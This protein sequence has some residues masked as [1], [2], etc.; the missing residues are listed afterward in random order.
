MPKKLPSQEWRIANDH[1]CL[2]PLRF[3]AVGVQKCVAALDSFQWLKYGVARGVETMLAHPLYFPYPHRYARQLHGEPI[4]LDAQHIL[5]T[6]ERRRSSDCQTM[7]ARQ[8]LPL[9]ICFE[10]DVLER[11]ERQV[12]KVAG[13]AS[14][15]EHTEVTKPCL[16]GLPMALR[17]TNRILLT[18]PLR[19]IK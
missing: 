18:L 17:T 4:D 7:R 15:I 16:E 5:W 13:A 12:Q 1:V 10:F 14:W 9:L 11:F 8:S 2:G 19:T 3:A 6:H